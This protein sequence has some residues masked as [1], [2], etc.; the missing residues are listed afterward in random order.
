M[1]YYQVIAE[2]TERLASLVL[3][4]VSICFDGTVQEF[5]NMNSDLDYR[6]IC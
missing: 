2:S 4:G 5:G 1:E 6:N 3:L